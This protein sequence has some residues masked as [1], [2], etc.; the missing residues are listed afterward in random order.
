MASSNLVGTG[1]A[2]LDQ[3]LLGGILKGNVILV[4]GAPGTGKSLLG[5]AFIYRGI[6]D[7]DEPGILVVF[8]TSPHKFIRD[9]ASFGWNLDDL[10]KQG[11]L[12]IIFTSPQVLD[13]ELRA[14]DSLLLETA[15]KM[16]A[17]RIFIDGISLLKTLSLSNGGNGDGASSYRQLLHQL[18]ESLQ[19]ENLTAML[20]HEVISREEQA[21]TLEI[22][23]FLADT[24]IC[25]R[26]EAVGPSVRRTLE[27]MKSRG[28]DYDY[29]K[30]TLRISGKGPEVFRRVQAPPRYAE[31]QP[32][33]STKRSA[34]GV[35]PLDTLLGGGIFDG[36]ITLVVGISGAGKTVLGVQLLL[37]GAV[38]QNKRGL[39]VSL[40]EHP[41]QVLRNA[42]TLDLNLQEQV[43]RG[44][45][46]VLFQSPQEL[47]L[48]VHFHDIVRTIE[49]NKIERLLI[50]GMTSYSTA[51]KD[52]QLYRDFFHALIG[53]AKHR[54]ISVFLNYENPELFGLTHFMPEF[55]VSSIVDNIILLNL[56]ELGNTL[57]R[58][59]TVAKARGSHHEFVTR[60]FAIGQGGISL[61]PVSEDLAIPILPFQSYYGLLSRAPTRYSPRIPHEPVIKE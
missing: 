16:G 12:K 33:S 20:S 3:I 25:L 4:E 13:Q 43:D 60:E 1:V 10:Q 44:T 47:D 2:G 32:T 54:L 55:A 41:A 34:I 11:K 26:R 48:D 40:D 14:P 35:G 21:A 46:T 39:L 61:L 18:F 7:H 50:D 58:A 45:V 53:F 23:E 27:I 9:V 24:V 8:E 42:E 19:R 28:Q 57:H 36:S 56:V 29:G 30:H 5:T 17:Q 22:G 31:A 49:E 52:Q 51:L 6:V 37:E 15:A 59:I 38:K